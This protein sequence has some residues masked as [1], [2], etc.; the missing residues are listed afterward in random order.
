MKMQK[1]VIF[2]KKLKIKMLKIKTIV[3]L[4]IIVIMQG[5]IEVLQIAYV[6]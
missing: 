1:F 5:N 6:I 2:V 3:K 4:E